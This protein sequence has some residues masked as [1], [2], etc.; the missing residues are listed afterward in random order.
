M[1]GM[2]SIAPFGV[3]MSD[4]LKEKLTVRAAQNGRSLNSEIVMILQEAV[5][6]ASTTPQTSAEH[7][8]AIQAEEFK[9]VVYDSLVKLYDK[10]NK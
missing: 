7:Q 9:K 8:A 5:D 3:R 6:A 1:K 2:R 4:E 10:D